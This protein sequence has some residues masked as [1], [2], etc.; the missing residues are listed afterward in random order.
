MS[1]F[2][3][4]T[5]GYLDASAGN[6]NDSNSGAEYGNLDPGQGI[7]FGQARIVAQFGA[8]PWSTNQ[9][10]APKSAERLMTLGVPP[11]PP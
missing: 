9:Y 5:A 6:E 8:T 2:Y 11:P 10:R 4:R 3:D 7:V 1:L